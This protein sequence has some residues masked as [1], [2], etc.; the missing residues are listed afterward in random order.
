MDTL[1][2]TSI[3]IDRGWYTVPLT[4]PTLYRLDNGKKSDAGMPNNWTK[5]HNEFNEIPTKI[6]SVLPG[7]K[8]NLL[9]IDCDS[10]ETTEMMETLINA[11]YPDYKAKTYS[12]GKL[13]ENKQLIKGSKWFF[14]HDP[15][16]PAMHTGPYKLEV[17]SGNGDD[18][19]Q[20][21]L[22]T[23]ANKTTTP[24]DHIPQLQPVPSTL[25]MLLDV[26]YKASKPQ[27]VNTSTSTNNHTF[28]LAPMVEKQLSR[29]TVSPTLFAIL[30][31]KAFRNQL[32][33]EKGYLHPNDIVDG[34]GNE[35]MTKVSAI[36]GSDKSI[37]K[38]LYQ[39][40]MHFINDQWEHPYSERE[41]ATKMDYMTSGAATTSNGSLWQYDPD[42]E[43]A[44][45]MDYNRVEQMMEYY[46]DPELLEIVEINHTTTRS[47]VLQPKQYGAALSLLTTKTIKG[48]NKAEIFHASV[49]A[50]TT[51]VEPTKPFGPQSDYKYNKFIASPAIEI[52]Q[53]PDTYKQDYTRPE[54]FHNYLRSLMPIDEDRNYIMS[55]L[56][57]KLTTFKYS[58]VVY[59]FVGAPGSG[60]GMFGKMVQKLVG[61]QYTAPD[62]GRTELIGLSNAWLEGKF[63]VM[64]EELHEALK[65]YADNQLGQSNIKRWTG[66]ETASI[67]KMRADP[68]PVPMLATFI[69]NQNGNT[70]RMDI[71]DRRYYFIDTP[72]TLDFNLGEEARATNIL[73]IAYYIATEYPLLS[74]RDY[75]IPP[76]SEHKQASIMEKQPYEVQVLTY[77][78]NGQFDIV[79]NM[80][81]STGASMSR[82]IEKRA[83]DYITEDS[84]ID[85][86][87][88]GTVLGES[89]NDGEILHKWKNG[90]KAGLLPGQPA[91]PYSNN[92]YRIRA[93]G[94][95]ETIEP[96]HEGE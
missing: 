51:V 20:V 57:T 75:V 54:A 52:I 2:D 85:I 46:L 92:K 43:L 96:I 21:F 84:L 11:I 29:S 14:T 5:Y 13:D 31:P 90:I 78:A 33:R 9:V 27:V 36:L 77:L 38:E 16:I 58:P 50:M 91:V 24:W 70:F 60:K 49:P 30:T 86:Y 80:I 7:A 40:M 37:S 39:R 83:D 6:G 41:L 67:K 17:F 65:G 34:E 61:E 45:F 56:R 12:I 64:F 95:S 72:D 3:Y 53:N 74:D 48:K 47:R 10:T 89:L 87:R 66:S 82:F 93:L 55:H 94:F 88:S 71:K 1:T 19:Q 25:K 79:Y 69:L 32:Y 81:N 62:L 15:D 73:D 68:Y 42:W 4:K 44:R 76:M 35:Y 26:W 18:K 8:S 23:P 22:P 28:N 59:Y 63:F